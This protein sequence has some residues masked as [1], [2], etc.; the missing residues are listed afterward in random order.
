[1]KFVSTKIV[2]KVT[3]ASLVI[4]LL[5]MAQAAIAQGFAAPIVDRAEEFRDGVFLLVGALASLVVLWQCFQGMTHKKTWP[6]IL[7]TCAW[8]VGAAC[9]VALV[10]WLWTMGQ[11]ISF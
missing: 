3:Q 8:V 7:E 11:S 6:D 10:A 1:M 9:S 5:G 4:A 2:S